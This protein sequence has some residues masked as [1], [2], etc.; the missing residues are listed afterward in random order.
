MILTEDGKLGIGVESATSE[1]HVEGD[2]LINGSLT[3]ESAAGVFNAYGLGNHYINGGFLQSVSDSYIRFSP[4]G[5]DGLGFGIPYESSG[6]KFHVRVVTGQAGGTTGWVQSSDD[7]LKTN[8]RPITSAL[9]IINK[10]APQLYSFTEPTENRSEQQ[11][12]FIAQEVQGAM[13]RV[14]S[15]DPPRLPSP[16][17]PSPVSHPAISISVRSSGRPQS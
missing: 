9:D 7:R 12:G 13:G 1:L 14:V 17:G 15:K 6:Y 2:A 10:L 8:E 16:A 5:V 11:A 3:L 4:G